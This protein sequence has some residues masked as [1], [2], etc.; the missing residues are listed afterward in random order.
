M[1]HLLANLV[2]AQVEEYPVGG[3]S[4][5]ALELEQGTGSL[6]QVMD[7]LLELALI[8]VIKLM[9]VWT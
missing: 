6:W 8:Q 7:R 1:G 3:E 4:L 2:V 5:S 9:W